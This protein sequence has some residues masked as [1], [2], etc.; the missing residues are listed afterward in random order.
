MTMEFAAV[1]SKITVLRK[2][3]SCFK[4]LDSAEREKAKD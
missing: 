2:R 1:T 3:L 4:A